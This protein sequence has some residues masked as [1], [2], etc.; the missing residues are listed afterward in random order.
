MA[1][2]D[3]DISVVDKYVGQII[4]LHRKAE[5][6]AQNELAVIIGVSLRTF[7][8]FEWGLERPSPKQLR[9]IC[10]TLDMSPADLFETLSLTGSK[11]E[12]PSM[13]IQDVL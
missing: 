11:L 7:Q 12:K 4:R 10:I 5:G 8:K 6:L 2:F 3:K 13:H 1:M 9:D